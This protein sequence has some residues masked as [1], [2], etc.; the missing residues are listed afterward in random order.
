MHLLTTELKQWIL[1]VGM[2]TILELA[3]I[4]KYRLHDLE[5]NKV[6]YQEDFI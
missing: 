5:I 3:G 1:G 4:S 6:L 2:V